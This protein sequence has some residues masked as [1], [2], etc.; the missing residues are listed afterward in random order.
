MIMSSFVMFAVRNF[1]PISL[2]VTLEVVKFWQGS[3]M[4]TDLM[5]YDRD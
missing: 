2:I 4:G 1:V 5:M 3:F